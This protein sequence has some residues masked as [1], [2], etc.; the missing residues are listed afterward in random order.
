VPRLRLSNSVT[1][2]VTLLIC[3]NPSWYSLL[4]CHHPISTTYIFFSKSHQSLISPCI[5]ITYL[6]NQ[7]S[8]SFRQ[9]CINYFPDDA[10]VCNSSSLS[11][12]FHHAFTD[13]NNNNNRTYIGIYRRTVVTSEALAA[14]RISVQWMPG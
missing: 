9:P 12:H 11:Q 14:G 7:L 6:C 5:W 10:T 13:N 2:L 8:V 1:P 4:I 3:T